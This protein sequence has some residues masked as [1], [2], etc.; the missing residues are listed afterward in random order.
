MPK[1]YQESFER[2][3]GLVE[4]IGEP[5][6]DVLRPPRYDDEEVGPSV[7]RS[8]VADVDL[9]DL[10][11]PGLYVARSQMTSCNF[12]RSDLHLSTFNW[13]D[14]THC[15]FTDCDLRGSDLRACNFAD[16]SFR[17]ADLSD[18]DVRGSAFER[19]DFSGATCNGLILNRRRGLLGWSFEE[20]KLPLSRDQQA[21]VKWTSEYTEPGGG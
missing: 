10:T 9:T 21:R 19:C 13:S 20:L 11:L 8:L 6:P 1:S 3:A 12:A 17:G 2:L 18:A 16:C 7:F 4:I 14:I 15:E 5:R